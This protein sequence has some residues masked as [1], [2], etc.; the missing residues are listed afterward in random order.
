V[1]LLVIFSATVDAGHHVFLFG[2]VPC[3][4]TKWQTYRTRRIALIYI[5]DRGTLNVRE[6]ITGRDLFEF[7]LFWL[8]IDQNCEYVLNAIEGNALVGGRAELFF[9][10][11]PLR[12]MFVTPH[13]W[14]S[15]APPCLPVRHVPPL[16]SWLAV[17]TTSFLWNNALCYKFKVTSS[18]TH[19]HALCWYKDIKCSRYWWNN[20]SRN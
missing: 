2:A 6:V 13:V 12:R 19:V 10:L 1:N 15:H 18:P 9:C 4:R 17:A 5:I 20:K 16:I 11:S 14:V 8:L 7:W 3:R